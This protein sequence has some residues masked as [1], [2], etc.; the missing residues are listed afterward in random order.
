[1]PFNAIIRLLRPLQW[2]KNAFVFLP[3][4]FGGRLLDFPLL[5]QCAVAA[6]AFSLA[7][8]AV[9]CLNDIRDAEKD[10]LHPEKRGR[11]IA[12]GMLSA[13]TGYAVMC[14]CLAAAFLMSLLLDGGGRV[15]VMVL[16][17]FYITMN[18]AY[19]IRLKRRAI[20][21]VLIIAVG[22]VLRVMVGGCATGVWLSE[23]III[24]TF[25]L[26]LFLAFAK[27]RDDVV[28][29]RKTGVAPRLNTN[30]YNLDF[31]NHVLTV[32]ATITI[33]AYVMY[34]LSP[35]TTARFQS[36]HVYLTA[37]FVLS[38]IIRY[39]Q[40]TLVDMK[41]GSP[42]RILVGDRFIQFCIAGWAASF[43]IIIYGQRLHITH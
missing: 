35:D 13:K 31:M 26:A 10:R 39:L 17:A 14:A 27:R 25:L 16:L 42:T 9:Y 21:D 20:V 37:V 15:S 1:M 23:W 24:M 34:A 43:F 29:L 18:A 22:F 41:S 6:A 12:A 33:V 2:T 30:R 7:A 3:V 28:L 4:F 11:P 19:C 5:L 32:V 36:R 8:S 40:L 38:G